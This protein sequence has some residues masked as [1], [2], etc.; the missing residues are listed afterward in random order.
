M[1]L[2]EEKR[3]QRRSPG[4]DATQ[5]SDGRTE[6]QNSVVGDG[7][8]PIKRA[9]APILQPPQASFGKISTVTY[10][11]DPVIEGGT[12]AALVTLL[13]GATGTKLRGQLRYI[14]G[15]NARKQ[16][17]PFQQFNIPNGGTASVV[18]ILILWSHLINF[19][20]KHLHLRTA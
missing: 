19:N 5:S 15:Q 2:P 1:A 8:Q 18:F 14:Y 11:P 13:T 17:T 12:G 3:N 16:A 6:L 7:K 9:V 10:S 20:C 4:T